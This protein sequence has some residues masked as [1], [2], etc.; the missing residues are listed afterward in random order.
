MMALFALAACDAFGGGE[1]H[2]SPD[3]VAPLQPGARVPA[4]SV[5]T[6]TG[7]SVDLAGLVSERGALLV[8]YRG[9]W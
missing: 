6:V 8:F 2:P 7:E 9:G 1:V 3:A 4:V 5:Q